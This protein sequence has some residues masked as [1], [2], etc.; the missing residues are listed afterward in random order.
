VTAQLELP[1]AHVA[2][3]SRPTW[4]ALVSCGRAKLDRPAPARELYIGSTFRMARRWAE[5]NADRWYILSALHGVLDPDRVVDPYDCSMEDLDHAY[6]WAPGRIEYGPSTGR[7]I[8][9]PGPPELWATVCRGQ[10]AVRGATG[11]DVVMLAGAAY[12]D[13]LGSWLDAWGTTVLYPLRGLGI[14]QQRGWLRRGL[15]ATP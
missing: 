9:H 1:L 14:G 10:L 7:R 13:R 12:A 15:E 3:P 2:A 11:G 8:T 5:R 4:I 6:R